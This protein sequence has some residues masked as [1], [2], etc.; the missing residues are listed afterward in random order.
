MKVVKAHPRQR[1]HKRP[2]RPKHATK[3]A[4]VDK[5]TLAY[6]TPATKDSIC[7]L[8]PATDLSKYIKIALIAGGS[9]AVIALLLTLQINSTTHKPSVLT[10]LDWQTIMRPQ[11]S[12]P[13]ISEFDTGFQV[14]FSD[15]DTLTIRKKMCENSHL[16]SQFH[17]RCIPREGKPPITL[18]IWSGGHYSA[19]FMRTATSDVFPFLQEHPSVTFFLEDI[20]TPPGDNECETRLIWSLATH[21]RISRQEHIVRPSS[22][23]LVFNPSIVAR[24]GKDIP[25]LTILCRSGWRNVQW[26]TKKFASAWDVDLSQLKVIV[27]ENPDLCKDT[28]RIRRIY[29]SMARIDSN[30]LSQEL[31]ESLL[32]DVDTSAIL[33]YNGDAHDTIYS[34]YP[35]GK[36]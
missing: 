32:P 7:R 31:F 30:R 13:T 18:G 26:R 20:N 33:A 25:A 5:N 21:N 10:P 17:T 27:S 36:C 6:H 9:I 3:K 28:R 14:S 15:D 29:S 2:A 16:P 34:Q 24:Y 8:I 1:T 19:D 35:R 23:E 11:L 4:S 12:L 22:R